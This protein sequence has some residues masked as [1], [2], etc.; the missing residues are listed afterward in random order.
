MNIHARK[1]T[2]I[3]YLSRLQNEKMI[4]KL[5]K[6]IYSEAY[7]SNLKPMTLSEFYARADASEKAIKK[8]QVTSVEDLEKESENW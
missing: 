4:S 3:E 8:G 2:L 1:L 7:E 5:E 6:L